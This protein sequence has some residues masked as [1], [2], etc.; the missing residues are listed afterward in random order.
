VGHPSVIFVLPVIRYQRELDLSALR[1][2]TQ[3]RSKTV[4]KENL[5][6]T[7][8]DENY[9][10]YCTF[11]GFS[12]EGGVVS[13]DFVS[14]SF[15]DVEWYWGLFTLANFINCSFVNCVFRGTTFAESRFVEC[16]MTNC[17][18]LRDNLDS[19]CTFPGTVAFRCSLEGVEG[20]SIE[21]VK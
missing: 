7:R 5:E 15:R 19:E 4:G 14:C 16:T 17:R 13:S 1:D 21:V 12:Q 10:K 3:V 9:F 20:F 2:G 6:G 8:L 11:D 18:F